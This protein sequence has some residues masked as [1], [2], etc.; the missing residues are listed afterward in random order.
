M[1][2]LSSFPQPF[3]PIFTTNGHQEHP[4]RKQRKKHHRSR[5]D[6]LLQSDDV[7]LSC[8]Y[9]DGE[10]KQ[11]KRFDH[12]VSFEMCLLIIHSVSNELN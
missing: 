1:R 12:R 8:S 4:M 7:I 11:Y 5:V 3:T 10:R 9:A 2:Q 6:S